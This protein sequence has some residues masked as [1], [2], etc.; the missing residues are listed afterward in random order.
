[1][2]TTN[3]RP[4]VLFL[5]RLSLHAN[6]FHFF[7]KYHLQSL[8]QQQQQQKQATEILQKTEIIRGRK[9]EGA[10]REREREAIVL[11]NHMSRI[12]TTRMASADVDAGSAAGSRWALNKNASRL[13]LNSATSFNYQ[14]IKSLLGLKTPRN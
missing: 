1:M 8:Q 6:T 9:G 10:R 13:K 3:G 12:A 5:V 2:G 14:S 4:F 7:F 11:L